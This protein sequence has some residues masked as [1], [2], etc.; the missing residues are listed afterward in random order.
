MRMFGGAGQQ[1]DA[2]AI[3]IATSERR[4]SDVVV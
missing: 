1:D 3:P 2:E 4:G